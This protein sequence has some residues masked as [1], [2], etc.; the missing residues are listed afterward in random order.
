MEQL[1][2]N[3]L[4]MYQDHL[5]LMMLVLREI[6]MLQEQQPLLILLLIILHL[7]HLVLVVQLFIIVM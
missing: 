1:H 3:H 4:S 2:Y 5:I 6:K 7:P